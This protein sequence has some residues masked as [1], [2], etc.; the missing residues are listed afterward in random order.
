MCLQLLGILLLLIARIFQAFYCD[1]WKSWTKNAQRGERVRKWRLRSSRP[2][3]Y[4]LQ[5]NRTETLTRKLWPRRRA[6]STRLSPSGCPLGHDVCTGQGAMPA[7]TA[8]NKDASGDVAMGDV[9]GVVIEP[10]EDTDQETRDLWKQHSEL[11]KKLHHV[12]GGMGAPAA[13]RRKIGEPEGSC[14][15]RQPSCK[16]L[17]Q[18]AA[19]GDGEIL[20]SETEPKCSSNLFANI[21][22]WGVLAEK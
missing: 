17:R 19:E 9:D 10:P 3:K 12:C 6:T 21:T 18:K 5:L 16:H 14:Q 4:P 2:A 8:S 15:K 7:A 20:S 11:E 1:G 22:C 13:K